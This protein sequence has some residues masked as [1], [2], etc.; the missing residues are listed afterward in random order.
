MPIRAQFS[1]SWSQRRLPKG[2]IQSPCRQFPPNA[3]A[4][5]WPT[6]WTC[7]FSMC[8]AGR[9]PDRLGCRG[10]PQMRHESSS[11]SSVTTETPGTQAA[12]S[13]LTS[14]FLKRKY[15]HSLEIL[16]G[17]GRNTTQTA[18]YLTES[19]AFIVSSVSINGPVHFLFLVP[20]NLQ[21]EMIERGTWHSICPATKGEGQ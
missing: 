11:V 6:C 2:C 19:R 16:T 21:R 4:G 1:D 12:D 14:S 5:V 18:R 9:R 15:F 8:R 10:C 20:G 17:E 3:S 7:C 13:P